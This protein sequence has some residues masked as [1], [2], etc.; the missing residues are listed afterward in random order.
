MHSGVALDLFEV[1]LGDVKNVVSS[2]IACSSGAS[3]NFSLPKHCNLQYSLRYP[4]KIG[5][6]F[7]P[8]GLYDAVG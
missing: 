8:K 5:S 4:D 7:M 2:M 3:G 6:T 1:T